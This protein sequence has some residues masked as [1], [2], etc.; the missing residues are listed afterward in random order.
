MFFQTRTR[1]KHNTLYFIITDKLT[2]AN[3]LQANSSIPIHGK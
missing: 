1:L 2:N 3:I